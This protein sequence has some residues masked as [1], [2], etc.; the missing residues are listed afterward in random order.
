MWRNFAA[1]RACKDKFYCYNKKQRDGEVVS[2]EAH[3]L[4]TRV[5]I[6]VP[7]HFDSLRL[8]QCKYN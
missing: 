7:Q 2:H 1:E 4:G 8:A 3:N 5:Q 6:P